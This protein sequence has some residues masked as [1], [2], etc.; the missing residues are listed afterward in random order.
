MLKNIAVVLGIV[1]IA[2]WIMG[3]IFWGNSKEK[4]EKAEKDLQDYRDKYAMVISKGDSIETVITNLREE[5]SNLQ[6]H[7]DSLENALVDL[8][9][10]NQMQ[11]VRTANLF[12]PDELVDEMRFAFPELKTAPLGIARVPHPETG[13]TIT[14]FQLPV[15]FVAT[16]ITDHREVDNFKRQIAALGEVNFTYKTYVAL[17]DSIIMLKEQKAEEYKKG[18]E[19]GLQRYEDVMKDYIE[20]L[21]N[22]PKIE[23]PSVTSLI[24]AGAAGVA[25][26][27]LIA[28]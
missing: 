8:R 7:I 26:G 3:F 19:Y 2:S 17:Q 20:T 4:I 14:T 15:Q 12:Q 10:E 1:L 18:L 22:P 13:F 16:F 5:E 27:V 24:A 6:T 21:K 23:W 9:Q 25:A 28:K 11:Q